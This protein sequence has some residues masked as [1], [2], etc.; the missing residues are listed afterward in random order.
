MSSKLDLMLMCNWQ[1]RFCLD[2]YGFALLLLI[3]ANVLQYQHQM[4]DIISFR[5]FPGHNLLGPLK[6]KNPV[7]WAHARCAH[8]LRRPW[9]QP[10][11]TVLLSSPVHAHGT[12][13]LRSADVHRYSTSLLSNAL[14]THPVF[15]HRLTSVPNVIILYTRKFF[16][17]VILGLTC[18]TTPYYSGGLHKW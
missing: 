1:S 12:A 10:P 6:R 13:F 2:Y 7:P 8:W 14:K 3:L 5:I 16:V 4:N 17:S 9:A 18:T 15:F 11:T